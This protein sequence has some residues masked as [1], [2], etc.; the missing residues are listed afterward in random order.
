MHRCLAAL[1]AVNSLR[2]N[3]LESGMFRGHAATLTASVIAAP[4]G[5]EQ[6]LY[7]AA[8]SLLVNV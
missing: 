3:R 8:G 1:A 4:F 7:K 2:F 6:T 5:V